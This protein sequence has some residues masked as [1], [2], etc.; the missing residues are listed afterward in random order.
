MT[1]SPGEPCGY[2]TP[3]Q[4]INRYVGTVHQSGCVDVACAGEN[5]PIDS[6]VNAAGQAD[7]VIVFV[8]LDQ[9]VEAETVDRESLLLPGRQP[10]LVQ[11][12]A[13]AS[14]GPVVVVLISGGS[15]DISFARDDP[16]VSAIVWA[17]Y[18]GQSGG[19]AIADVLFGAV[20]PGGRL[21]MTWYPQEFADRVPMTEMGMRADPPRGYPGRT[22]RFYTGPVVYPFGHG[23]SYSKFAYSIAQAPAEFTVRLNGGRQPAV[24]NST[25]PARAV[26]VNH[27]RCDGSI[28]PVHVDVTNRGELDG[29]HSVLVY[30]TRPIDAEGWVPQKQLVAFEKVHVASGETARVK[31]GV[32]VCAGLSFADN[33]GIRRIMIGDHKLEIGDLTHNVALRVEMNPV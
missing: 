20:N 17:G 32:D 25:G 21:P 2:V 14:R 6:A 22:Y 30:S 5:Q 33:Y 9:S 28:M 1:I 26:R 12:A 24:A 3:L 18:P 4:G 15:L 16:R 7:A 23:L 11:K 29:V 19:Q 27:A 13:A 8:G 10:E 31:L